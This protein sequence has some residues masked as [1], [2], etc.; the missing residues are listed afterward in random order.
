MKKIILILFACFLCLENVQSQT[1]DTTINICDITFQKNSLD[2]KWIF[3]DTNSFKISDGHILYTNYNTKPKTDWVDTLKMIY[4]SKYNIV[5]YKFCVNASYTNNPYTPIYK[6]GIKDTITIQKDITSGIDSN[7]LNSYN[8]SFFIISDDKLGGIIF[9]SY[10]VLT[11]DTTT[12][13]SGIGNISKPIYDISYQN[14]KFTSTSKIDNIKV[15]N[16]SGQL[17]QEGKITDD[18]DLQPYQ[19][20]ICIF[21]DVYRK[22]MMILN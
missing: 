11:V 19:V 17:L 21:N 9:K 12:V 8:I 13:V 10:V 22:R 3:T 16:V 5:K 18:Y 15:Y 14:Q 6:I 7:I 20:Y 4:N 1:M 2:S